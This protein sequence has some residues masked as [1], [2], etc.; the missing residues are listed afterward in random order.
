MLFKDCFKKIETAAGRSVSADERENLRSRYEA[1]FLDE[2]KRGD[3][4]ADNAMQAAFNR[5]MQEA[6]ADKQ[7][8]KYLSDLNAL[9]IS[10]I[11]SLAER[12]AARTG[13]SKIDAISRLL[14]YVPDNRTGEGSVDKKAEAIY[15]MYSAPLHRIGNA[16]G[17]K[18]AGI[19]QRAD[20]VE[21]FT[22]HLLGEKFK[23]GHY[24]DVTPDEIITLKS[25]AEEW[26]IT[27]EQLRVRTNKAGGNIGKL[28]SWAYPQS[29]DAHRTLKICEKMNKADPARAFVELMSPR[30]NRAKMV[31][32]FDMPL[33]NEALDALLRASYLSIVTEGSNKVRSSGG[34]GSSVANRG[35]QQRV[36]HFDS[37]KDMLLIQA[38]FGGHQLLEVLDSHARNATAQI[39]LMEF[40]GPSVR[41]NIDTLIAQYKAEL[42]KRGII[43]GKGDAVTI[44][45]I[46]A[47]LNI[48]TGTAS[49]VD[50]LNAG[51]FA[52]GLRNLQI[53][54]LAGAA[55]ASLTG[56]PVQYRMQSILHAWD[57]NLPLQKRLQYVMKKQVQV[58]GEVSKALISSGYRE[59]VANMGL[60]AEAMNQSIY[61]NG[62]D[63]VNSGWTNTVPA[64]VMKFSALGHLTNARREGM[65]VI[66]LLGITDKLKYDFDNLGHID[67]K[68]IEGGGITR[69]DWEIFKLA[70]RVQIGDKEVVTPD[71]IMKIE[72]VPP[73]RLQKAAE[74]LSV[75]MLNEDKLN[76]LEP[77]LRLRAA[78]LAGLHGGVMH[79]GAL[80]DE[81]FANFYQFKAFPHAFM[82]SY[83]SRA[84]MFDSKMGKAS[85]VAAMVAM[86]TIGGAATNQVWNLLSGRDIESMDPEENPGFFGRAL[87]RGGGLS[88]FGDYLQ[89]DVTWNGWLDA[90]KFVAGPATGQALLYGGTAL[91][92]GQDALDIGMASL[93]GET[94]DDEAREKKWSRQMDAHVRDA[95]SLAPTNL[96]YSRALV[97][98][99]LFNQIGEYL[100]PGYTDRMKERAM[101]MTGAEHFWNPGNVTDIRAPGIGGEAGNE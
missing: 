93:N 74:A 86:S 20:K 90:S 47:Q 17:S 30:L 91:M 45:Q 54:R 52:Q 32:E 92:A 43:A 34:V 58:T 62:E 53:S 22:R 69:E 6:E 36:L 55:I 98:R 67:T 57:Q 51:R 35:S 78:K 12:V 31:D 66:T 37:A 40:G 41:T 25:A 61:R 39:A 8:A 50:R 16:L 84:Q 82:S 13:K 19:M 96:W 65:R 95:K 68:L 9:K 27:A 5:L 85:Y 15:Q 72:G 49:V 23:D 97:D 21:I 44:N 73:A 89:S 101:G 3:Q 4:T 87:M 10:S 1:R 99:L 24:P 56:D 2:I 59:A 81:L 28:E 77:T 11:D 83:L 7:R 100:R 60:A 63:M 79:K 14:A 64:L 88:F 29:W 70:E 46:N 26:Q 33:S 76:V 18:M 71:S 38:Q 48:L 80:R 75:Y 94:E 42:G